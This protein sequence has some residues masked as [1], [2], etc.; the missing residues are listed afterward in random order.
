M[1]LDCIPDIVSAWFT[2][3]KSGHVELTLFC[4]KIMPSY[5]DWIDIALVTSDDFAKLFFSLFSFEKFKE[6]VTDCL[7]TVCS[8][9]SNFVTILFEITLKQIVCKGM[10]QQ[11][12]LNLIVKLQL[13]QLLQ[14]VKL[15]SLNED[16]TFAVNFSSL[17]QAVAC[18]LL[19]MFKQ[20][21]QSSKIQSKNAIK[22]ENNL[23]THQMMQAGQILDSL[24]PILVTLLGDENDEVSSN[25]LA[26]FDLY[27]S[28]F[29]VKEIFD[30]RSQQLAALLEVIRTKCRYTEEFEFD[31]SK[32]SEYEA[33]IL[34]YRRVLL[35]FSFSC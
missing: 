5:I 28:L 34:E 6:G 12:K 26:F 23:E 16:D 7:T 1:R 9:L 25:V 11:N 18:A 14:S 17:T 19:D 35:L 13:P 2:I 29:K 21:Y 10:D 8:I 15:D 32:Q 30:S 4:L 27:V 22:K 20:L 24:L 33:S 3:L 31:I